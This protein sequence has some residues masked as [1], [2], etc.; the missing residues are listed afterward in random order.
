MLFYRIGEPLEIVCNGEQPQTTAS[1][2]FKSP[3]FVQIYI[4]SAEVLRGISQFGKIIVYIKL[5]YHKKHIFL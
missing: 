3:I 5:G 2:L 1:G 4:N